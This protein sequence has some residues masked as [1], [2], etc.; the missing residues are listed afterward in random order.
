M[1]QLLVNL[2]ILFSQPTG[3]ANYAANLFPYLKPLD[4]TLLISPTASSRFC[5]ATTYTCYPIPGNLSPEQG[6]KGHFRRL[7]WTQFQ[8]PRI[9]KKLRT[10][11]LFSPVPE[12]PLFTNC[13]YVV[14]VHDLIGLRFP[15][16][17]SPLTTYQ[18]YYI[19]QVL[20]QAE[21]II[22]N[23][24]ATARDLTDFF[25]IPAA[26]ITP[27][28]LAYDA[29]HYYYQDLRKCPLNPPILGDFD[30]ITPQNWGAGGQNQLNFVSPN[31]V[32]TV[33]GEKDRENRENCPYF[34]YIGRPDPHK[35][36]HRLIEAFAGLAN[37]HDY[38]LWIAGA[39]DKRYTPL[40]EAQA[41]QLDISSQ[42]KFLGYVP[43]HQL[44]T[45]IRNAIAFV[46]PSLWE[47]FGIPVLEAMACGT[48][49]I[50]ANLS[51]LPEVAGDAAILINPYN[52]EEITAAMA[53]VAT[54]SQMRSHLRMAGLARASEF[55]WQKTGQ[56]TVE[57]LTHIAKG[58]GNRE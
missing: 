58:T 16:G 17:F 39:T 51:S 46:F 55:S 44:P 1:S 30:I 57:I 23:S 3:I 21:H 56:A 12:A 6:T 26:K 36:L 2:S 4:P 52:P 24:R 41:E 7:L 29:N 34:L 20:G 11:L 50:T 47:G 35:N 27:I 49:V 43:Q 40:L 42:V 10:H 8:L 45:M 9:Y 28:L 54:D 37:C 19:P 32:D 15:Q 22:C 14:M 18:R 33:D 31:Y 48:P 53:A 25:E 38:Q 5:S 13:R